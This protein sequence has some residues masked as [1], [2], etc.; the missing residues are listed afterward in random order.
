MTIITNEGLRDDTADGYDDIQTKMAEFSATQ[1][2]YC[3]SGMV[4][5][6][7]AYLQVSLS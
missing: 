6:L 1:C 2:G 4:M 3:S 5:N 7:Y